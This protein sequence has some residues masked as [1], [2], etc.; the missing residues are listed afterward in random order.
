MVELWFL[1][2]AITL[3]ADGRHWLFLLPAVENQAESLMA[4]TA[5]IFKTPLAQ[6]GA[7]KFGAE[8]PGPA[9]V[10]SSPSTLEIYLCKHSNFYCSPGSL[11]Y[12]G[13]IS[14]IE[15]EWASGIMTDVCLWI[16]RL[17]LS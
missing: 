8:S 3:T 12:D 2:F 10:D 7:G 15:L 6:A 5:L 11:Q 1:H 9:M 17:V 4:R 13:G 14:D 16:W